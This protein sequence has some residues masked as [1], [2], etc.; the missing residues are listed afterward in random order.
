MRFGLA[1]VTG[2][3]LLAAVPASAISVL[4]IAAFGDNAVAVQTA[5]PGLLEADVA[6]WNTTP[7]TL[8]LLGE[9]AD[10]G[11]FAFNSVVDFYTGVS[12]GQNV[13]SLTLSLGGGAT[14]DFVGTV[15]PAFSGVAIR[16]NAGR[17][18]L[19]LAFSSPGEGFG[20]TLGNV[21]GGDDFLILLPQSGDSFTLTFGA[22]V[23]EPASWALMISGFGLVGVALRRSAVVAAG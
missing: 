15:V 13:R 17:D 4:D 9:T 6:I 22:A 2:A 3:A 23:P 18:L 19:T 7:I 20:V 16:L 12:I 1:I 11:S 10:N 8:R 5:A 14:F 21:T